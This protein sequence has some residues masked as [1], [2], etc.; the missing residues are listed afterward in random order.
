VTHGLRQ[1]WRGQHLGVVVGMDVDDARNHPLALGVDDVRAAV[2]IQRSG[3]DSGHAAV[4][5]PDVADGRWPSAAVEPPAVDDHCVE[6][7]CD[8]LT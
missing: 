3:G 1:L 8:H 6:S 7:Q 2:G 4:A 5:Y